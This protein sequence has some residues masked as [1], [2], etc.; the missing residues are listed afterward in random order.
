MPRVS[1]REQIK[2]CIRDRVY[3]R[4]EAKSSLVWSDGAVKLYTIT[5]VYRCV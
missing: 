1:G 5:F 3:R 4:M 2:M